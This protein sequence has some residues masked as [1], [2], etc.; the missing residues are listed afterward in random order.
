MLDPQNLA[1]VERGAQPPRLGFE[2]FG[3][4]RVVRDDLDVVHVRVRSDRHQR[5]M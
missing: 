4:G 1:G 3:P 5:G 2:Q